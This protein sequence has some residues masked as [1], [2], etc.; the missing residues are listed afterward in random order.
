MRRL[1]LFAALV[2]L[3]RPAMA[4][5][6]LKV[7]VGQQAPW[8]AALDPDCNALSL[9]MLLEKHGTRGAVV[10][11]W[12]S[13]CKACVA[14]LKELAAGQARLRKAGIGVLLVNVMDTPEGMEKVV[15]DLKLQGLPLIRDATG[16]VVDALGL[17]KDE[18][19]AL[20]L[21]F[22]VNAKNVVKLVLHE[23]VGDYVA[24]MLAALEHEPR[25]GEPG[26]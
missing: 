13:W 11:V 7:V 24:R 6:S 15:H 19:L 22:A 18:K 9:G 4:A 1:I 25:R 8:V 10:Q 3:A 2:S 12:A 14:E 17:S 23:K 16:A 21:S 5:D 20:P 26:K